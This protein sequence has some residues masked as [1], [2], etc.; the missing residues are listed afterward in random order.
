MAAAFSCVPFGIDASGRLLVAASIMPMPWRDGASLP[1]GMTA[2]RIAEDGRLSF[3]RKYDVE[4]GAS[5]Q[6][7]SGM[8]AL[9]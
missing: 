5:Q 2:F 8:L 7:W 1:A 3:V 6:F 9:P 4:V